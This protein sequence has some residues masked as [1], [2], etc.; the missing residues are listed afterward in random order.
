MEADTKM[1]VNDLPEEIYNIVGTQ[2]YTVD[3]IG[4]SGSENVFG[5]IGN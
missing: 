5:C 4:E 1:R 2:G 3:Y